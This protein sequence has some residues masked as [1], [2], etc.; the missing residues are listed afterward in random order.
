MSTAAQREHRS[1]SR[2]LDY[3]LYIGIAFAFI[4]ITFFVQ[5]KW[6]HDA[7]IR[8]FGLVGFTLGL[9]GFFLQESRELFHV[10]RFWE[11]TGAL[12]IIHL[13]V[14]TVVLL[15]VEEWRLPWFMVMVFE[16]PLF[17]FFRSRIATGS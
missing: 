12:L 4:G 15:H 5:A 2:V 8:G 9:F 7:F 13:L 11:V 10:R 14:F 16:Y 17:V 3:V 6:G 1:R